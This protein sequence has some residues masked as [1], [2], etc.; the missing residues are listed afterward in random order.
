M[1]SELSRSWGRSQ[2]EIRGGRQIPPT[3]PQYSVVWTPHNHVSTEVAVA[4]CGGC[5][6]WEA[7][8]A[9]EKGHRGTAI[10]A[11]VGREQ[12]GGGNHG[13][14]AFQ[15]YRSQPPAFTHEETEA[16]HH[17]MV[18]QGRDPVFSC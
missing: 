3:H 14:I 17:L 16:C 18:D 7:D 1:H 5:L 8:A 6:V 10:R 15:S 12:L 9:R 13:T 11:G 2:A 4:Q